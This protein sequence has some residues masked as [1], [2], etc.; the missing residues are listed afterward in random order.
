MKKKKLFTKFDFQ[1]LQKII[2]DKHVLDDQD[3]GDVNTLQY[4]L[5]H[6]KLV[7]STEIRPNIVTMNS[8]FSLKNIGNGKKEVYS[9]VFPNDSGD[10]KTKINVFSKIGA[11]IL[12]SS[13]G[14]VI[15]TSPTD[16][17]YFVIEEIL[18]QPEAEGDYHV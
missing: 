9:L 18:Y 13:I 14:T 2:N 10:D 3:A 1:R 15:Q 12:G 17:Q 11:Q 7:D 16:N 4:Y 8:K 6:S 5:T